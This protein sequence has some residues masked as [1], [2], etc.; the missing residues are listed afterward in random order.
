MM[1]RE[2]GFPRKLKLFNNNIQVLMNNF[3]QKTDSR[4]QIII[5]TSIIFVTLLVAAAIFLFVIK[6]YD[7]STE[8]KNDS[9][10]TESQAG[11]GKS[12]I[13]TDTI[14]IKILEGSYRGTRE[15]MDGSIEAVLLQISGLNINEKSFSYILNIG[16]NKKFRGIGRIDTE[17][18]LLNSDMIG[19]IHYNF[20]E[21]R[22]IILTSISDVSNSKYNLI[23]ER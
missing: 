15:S 5:W 17:K 1:R 10:L 23:R 4:R 20:D 8:N 2:G 18:K 16:I 9:L 6:K 13:L 22:N 7:S 14:D 3:N 19:D 11:D 21:K 12:G